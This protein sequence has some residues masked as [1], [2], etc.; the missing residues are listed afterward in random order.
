MQI[1]FIGTGGLCVAPRDYVS[2][3]SG[4][5][6]LITFDLPEAFYSQLYIDGHAVV[7]IAPG[8]RGGVVTI[9]VAPRLAALSE[10]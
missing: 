1:Q 5:A 8:F 9:T 2:T 10:E 7:G 6:V 3:N 4:A